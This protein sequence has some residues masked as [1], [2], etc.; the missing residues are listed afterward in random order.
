MT[1][2][3]VPQCSSPGAGIDIVMIMSSVCLSVCLSGTL[4]IVA[5]KC[6]S[7]RTGSAVLG[8]RSPTPILSPQ[9]PHPQNIHIR[10][11]HWQHADHGCPRQR[12]VAIPF[13][14]QQRCLT[15]EKYDR[16]SQKQ[17]CFSLNIYLIMQCILQLVGS[18]Y[19]S[20]MVR[21]C[22]SENHVNRKKHKKQKRFCFLA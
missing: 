6:L 8:K 11:S 9:T 17:L 18:L 3:L 20:G 13:F 10:N 19:T 7:K 22:S 12:S 1:E 21:M 15:S 2:S 4:C 5:P 16:L 14:V